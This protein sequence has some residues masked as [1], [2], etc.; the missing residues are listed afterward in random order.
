[1]SFLPG[2]LIGWSRVGA[3]VGTQFVLFSVRILFFAP[4]LYYGN[5]TV[6]FVVTYEYILLV[7]LHFL[8]LVVRKG[9]WTY[10]FPSAAEVQKGI[11][12]F[13][14]QQFVIS[15]TARIT[16]V[17]SFIMACWFKLG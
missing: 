17:F 2:K 5:G 12:P 16:F 6:D 7:K 13:W 15:R 1:L 11:I 3:R 9:I 8:V 14:R 4:I 10:L